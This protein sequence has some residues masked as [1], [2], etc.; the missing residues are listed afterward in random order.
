MK[1]INVISFPWVTERSSGQ[2]GRKEPA[3]KKMIRIIYRKY[4]FLLA[5]I[6]KTDH[7]KYKKY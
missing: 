3:E 6:K 4:R 1:S 7:L 5:L 2:P